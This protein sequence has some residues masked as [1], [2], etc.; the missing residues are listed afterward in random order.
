M[1]KSLF[2][3]KAKD[4]THAVFG[5]T[6]EGEVLAIPISDCPHLLIAGE[7]RSGKSVYVNNICVSMMTHASPEE[8]KI[9]WIDPKIVEAVAYKGLPYSWADPVTDMGDAYGLLAYMVWM[10]DERYK[11]LAQAGCKN[12]A[13]YNDFVDNNPEK[14]AEMGLERFYYLVVIIDEFSDLIMQERTVEDLI[15]RLA[16]KARA[17]GIHVIICTQRPDAQTLSPLIKANIPGRVGLRTVN[18]ANSAIILDQEGCEKLQGYGD[19]LVKV[20]GDIT[21]CQGPYLSNE[22]IEAIFSYLRD[23]YGEPEFIDYKQLSVDLG[24][25]MWCQDYPAGT[26]WAE[27]HVKKKSRTFR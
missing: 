14:A 10:M 12:I 1:A 4:P 22:E 15:I 17:A 23:K 6:I 3:T 25:A 24:L 8:L 27:K 26:P 21:R 9:T 7:T 13:E 11:M 5:K 18:A 19:S 20:G 2:K 16:Q